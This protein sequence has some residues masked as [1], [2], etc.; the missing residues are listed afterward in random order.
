MKKLLVFGVIVLFLGVAIAPSINANISKITVIDNHNV[1]LL[2]ETVRLSC[3]YHTLKGIEE[4]EKEVSAEDTEHLSQL[5]DSSDIDAVASELSRLGLLPE[6]MDVK[7][8]KDLISGEYGRR[9]FEKYEEKL[10]DIS[11]KESEVKQN[12]FCAVSG[13]AV[14]SILMTP[15]LQSVVGV[16]IFITISLMELAQY[17]NPFPFVALSLL[18]L[19]FFFLGIT[20]AIMWAYM[21]QPFKA[22][23]F[24]Y[25]RLED[26]TLPPH[27]D[28]NVNT[29]GL[30]GKWWMHSRQIYLHM[31]G[32]LGIW[33]S[34][35]DGVGDLACEFKGFALYVEAEV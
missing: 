11:L 9:N 16:L 4:I 17:L 32:F 25:V 33:I 12:L 34:Y 10:R 13:D 18:F 20:D 21:F 31:I 3:S 14:D 35:H 2:E 26:S 7:Q 30:F 24:P 28:A 23:M 5:M 8:V 29:S 6:T 1:S 22:M 27:V 19:A 15:A